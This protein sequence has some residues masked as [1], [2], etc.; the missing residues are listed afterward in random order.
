M[1]VFSL[2][3]AAGNPVTLDTLRTL[4]QKLGVTIDED[5]EE[6]YRRLLAVFHDT[7]VQIMALDDYIPVSD[8]VRFPREAVYFPDS[9]EN[10]HGAWAWKCSIRDKNPERSGILSN[11]R[12]TLK[13]MISVKDVPMLLG[14][15]FVKDYV[16]VC[17]PRVAIL[18]ADCAE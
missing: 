12:F 16:P 10:T 4:T 3:A 7:A 6:D 14:T 15:N 2:D 1:S 9:R 17:E 18:L 8:T 13:D 11:K 5:E